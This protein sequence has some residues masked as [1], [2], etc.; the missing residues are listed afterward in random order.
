MT[1]IDFRYSISILRVH[2]IRRL[3]IRFGHHLPI[4][5]GDLYVRCPVVFSILLLTDEYTYPV[6]GGL[7]YRGVWEG[8]IL[9]FR[10]T[11]HTLIPSTNFSSRS[12]V[13]RGYSMIWWCWYVA[14]PPGRRS[15]PISV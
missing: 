15:L 12:A 1:T 11:F 4:R 5:Y 14:P 10:M 6:A 7:H 2:L 13:G 9:Y 8:W 3:T